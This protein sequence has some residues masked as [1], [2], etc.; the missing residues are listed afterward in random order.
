MK[1]HITVTLRQPLRQVALP[2]WVDAKT[3]PRLRTERFLA[4]VDALF[5]RHGLAFTATREYEPAGADW[6]A[7]EVASGLDRVYRLVLQSDAKIPP[8][9]IDAIR[10]VPE[11]EQVRAGVI[12]GMDLQPQHAL[13]FSARTDRAS[14]DAVYLEEAHAFSE[15]DESIT[16]AV[17]DTGVDLNHPEYR[18]ALVEGYDFVDILDGASEFIGDYLGADPTPEDEVGH[19]THVAGIIAGRGRNMPRG[20]APKCRILPVRV[21]AA[22][23]KDGRPVGAGLVENIN[24]G[25]KWAI[26]HGADVINMSLGVRHTGGG[27]PHKEVIDYAQRKGVT[28]VAAS[29]NDGRHELYYPGAFPSVIAVGAA[30][31]RG[32]VAEFST[33]GDQ[34][35]FIAPG[36]DV[37]SSALED[38]YAFST[39]TSHAAPFVT[40]AVALL[41][42]HARALG[43]DC[44][45]RQV[46]H[47][48]KHTSDKVDRG[49]KHP[50]AGYGR[51]NIA[52]GL[53]Y[54]DYKL[55]AAR[56]TSHVYH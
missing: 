5:A 3:Q 56:R 27:L 22:M 45:D 28:V 13:S 41:K 51:L 43:R 20:V 11:V 1:P 23:N 55:N 6:S 25:V 18:H 10:L 40:G 19:G 32:E 47:V 30:D 21:L 31:D 46:K 15:G 50:K 8:A 53:R 37:Y 36:V 44:N 34:V 48:L 26:D 35:S 38:G 24:N 42:A 14:R 7:Q 49:F 12:G 9:L 16:V 52:D 39:G 17:L 29:G 33:Y 2:Y 4:P 54:L